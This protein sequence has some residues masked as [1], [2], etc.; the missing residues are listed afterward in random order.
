[1]C[2]DFF[3]GGFDTLFKSSWKE[4]GGKYIGSVEVNGGKVSCKILYVADISKILFLQTDIID[5]T[6]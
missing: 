2:T 1:M 3:S 5:H 6:Q 4:M